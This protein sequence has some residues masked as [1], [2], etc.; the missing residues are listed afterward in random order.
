VI[1]V[2]PKW[3]FQFGNTTNNIYHAGKGEG[4]PM[5]QHTFAHA[6]VVSTGSI[7]IRKGGKETVADKNTQPILL[8]ANEPHEIEALEPGTVFTNIF[9]TQG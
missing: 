1:A 5:H 3:S 4:L 9:Q 2:P 8:V 7:V 6:T